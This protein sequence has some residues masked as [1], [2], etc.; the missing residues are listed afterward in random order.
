MFV[1]VDL[2]PD[3]SVVSLAEPDDCRRF[4]VEVEGQGHAPAVDDALQS[5]GTGWLDGDG[6]AFVRVDRVRDLA[7]G[8]VGDDWP[9][10]FAGMLDFARD[11]GW[12]SDDGEAIRAHLEWR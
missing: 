12:L 4:H 10:R 9:I 11:K 1:L 8:R 3:T 7:A 2:E 5:T 6:G